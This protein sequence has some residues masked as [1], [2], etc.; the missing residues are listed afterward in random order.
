MGEAD[1]LV[2]GLWFMVSAGCDLTDLD[3]FFLPSFLY[4]LSP[5]YYFYYLLAPR[6]GKYFIGGSNGLQN[7]FQLGQ[8]RRL[9]L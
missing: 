7:N 6:S 1:M 2:V 8:S 5:I 4:L 9:G 3:S